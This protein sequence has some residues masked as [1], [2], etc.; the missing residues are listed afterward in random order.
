MLES[1][2]E[3][4]SKE[5]YQALENSKKE[6]ILKEKKNHRSFVEIWKIHQMH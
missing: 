3:K 2:T 1:Q 5:I 6:K 4:T